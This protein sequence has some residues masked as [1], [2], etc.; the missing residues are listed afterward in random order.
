MAALD[1]RVSR[2]LHGG[3]AEKANK[4]VVNEAR[5]RTRELALLWTRKACR[6]Q[7]LGTR[8][9][10]TAT[11]DRVTGLP[12]RGDRGLMA[13]AAGRVD[14]TLRARVVPVVRVESLPP[15]PP[16]CP[17]APLSVRD[18]GERNGRTAAPRPA[19]SPRPTWERVLQHPARGFPEYRRH[20][21]IFL[22]KSIQC[23]I[24]LS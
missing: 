22:R 20:R 2:V 13:L 11:C 17:R 16:V 3:Q 19:H 5:A 7:P 1:V 18:D 4:T 6:H 14:H 12:D 24:S 21:H 10:G 15:Y 9:Q 8:G 23:A